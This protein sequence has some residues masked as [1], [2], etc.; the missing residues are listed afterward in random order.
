MSSTI[1]DL[2][3]G[4]TTSVIAGFSVWFW[5]RLRHTLDLNHKSGFFG[6]RPNENCL[7]VINHNPRGRDLLSHWDVETVVEIV[8]VKVSS[9]KAGGFSVWGPLKA[10]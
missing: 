10:V 4:L 3:I 7:V 2:L 6:T 1:P 9:G 8:K 5:Q